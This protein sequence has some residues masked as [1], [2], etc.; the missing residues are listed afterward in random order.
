MSSSLETSDPPSAKRFESRYS[1][2]ESKSTRHVGV[3]TLT[4]RSNRTRCGVVEKEPDVLPCV[5]I[6]FDDEESDGMDLGSDP[7]HSS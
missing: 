2:K 3:Y 4:N 7:E 5:F 6:A 1:R